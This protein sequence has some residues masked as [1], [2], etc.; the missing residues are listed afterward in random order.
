M[1]ERVA[2]APKWGKSGAASKLAGLSIPTLLQAERRGLIKSKIVRIWGDRGTRIW[3][4]DSIRR[5]L[6][7]EV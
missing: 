6:G 1:K 7:E 5:F 2:S 3:D 4:L